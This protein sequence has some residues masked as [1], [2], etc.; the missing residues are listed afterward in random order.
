MVVI[1]RL[2]SHI[3]YGNSESR[4]FFWIA[5][6]KSGNDRIK[7]LKRIQNHSNTLSANRYQQKYG[8]FTRKIPD[9]LE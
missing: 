7:D 1:I 9:K 3:K 5:R 8:Q 2:D 6:S 4:P